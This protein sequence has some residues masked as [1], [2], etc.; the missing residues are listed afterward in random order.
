MLHLRLLALVA[1]VGCGSPERETVRTVAA[2]ALECP[3]LEVVV[4]SL[5]DEDA[6]AECR[7]RGVMLV[8][9]G[10]QWIVMSPYPV[11]Q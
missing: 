5:T 6:T 4:Q 1:L 3:R 11:G 9:Q 8:H 10:E 7:D 2:A